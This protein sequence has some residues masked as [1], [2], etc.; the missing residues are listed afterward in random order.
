MPFSYDLSRS[1]LRAYFE[2][3]SPTFYATMYV[4]LWDGDPGRDGA[5][6]TEISGNAYARQVI[7]WH[8]VAGT[9]DPGPLLNTV[10]TF[11]TATP[12]A[13]GLVTHYAYLT[14]ATITT[15]Y[16]LGTGALTVAKTVGAGDTFRLPDSNM[17]SP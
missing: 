9:G 2:N 12:S 15:G 10:V 13:W 8:D 14:H 6:G 1:L 7:T 3:I 11:P 16:L 17:W 4:A 5:S